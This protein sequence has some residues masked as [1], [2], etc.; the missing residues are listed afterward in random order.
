[1]LVYIYFG[2]PIVIGCVANIKQ[3]NISKNADF[4]P[5]VSILIPA[6]NEE[7]C[8]EATIQNKLDLDYPNGKLEIL[9]VSDGSTDNT[10]KIVRAIAE[11]EPQVTIRLFRQVPRAGK[12]SGLNMIVPE[13]KCE[14]LVF[15]DANSIYDVGALK[16]LVNNFADSSVGYVTGKMVYVN[17]DGALVGDGCSAYMR[18]ENR[19]RKYE[20]ATGSIV[21]VDGGIDAIRKNLYQP[22]NA[23]QLP[24]FVQPLK[25]VEKGFRVVYEPEALLKEQALN[26]VVSE[27]RMRVRVSLRALWAM[28]DMKKLFNPIAFGFFS[29]Q[30]FSH[31]LLRYFGFVAQIILFVSNLFLVFSGSFFLFSFL[32][33]IVFF[34]LAWLGHVFKEEANQPVYLSLPYYF[35]LLNLSSAQAAWRYF[36]GEKQVIWNPR[37][38]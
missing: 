15:S 21:G 4:E 23:D 17:A 36:K 5:F 19:L 2:Y 25:V 35:I 32:S 31:K 1:M 26:D 18:Y 11:R 14:I 30:L 9:V 29:F 38:G 28:H 16:K 27:Y 33:Q 24:D 10:D 8:I 22:L 7:A 3:K 20:S 37:S 13:T 12:T 6:F 34:A